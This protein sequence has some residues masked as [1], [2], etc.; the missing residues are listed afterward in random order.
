MAAPIRQHPDVTA[1]AEAVQAARTREALPKGYLDFR[2][3]V[4]TI[5][6]TPVQGAGTAAPDLENDEIERRLRAG[7][8]LLD[9]DEAPFESAPYRLL[10]VRIARRMKADTIA[11]GAELSE[12]L[13]RQTGSLDADA[14]AR[15][16]LRRD[17]EALADA[18]GLVGISPSLL[19]FAVAHALHPV[20]SPLR[21]ALAPRV[22]QDLWMR[23]H[24]PVCGGEP[25]MGRLVKD[26]Q[27]ARILHCPAC[28]MEWRHRRIVC[29]HCANEDHTKMEV[30][31]AEV[32]SPAR[33]EACK[34]CGRYL[35]EKDERKLAE[36][37][38]VNIAAEE[39][40]SLDLDL[41]AE[42]AGYAN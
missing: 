40:V 12:A 22:R 41:A 35:K 13:E 11:G 33:V 31:F 38:V 30:L 2:L 14:L 21:E 32:G 26:P 19:R 27:G 3:E 34:A 5:A 28:G 6:R 37:V 4:L 25:D 36:G 23:G 39:I 16:V 24:C 17:G 18:A 29:P 1:A 15:A 20:L 9:P 10:L 8:S 7:E 42:E